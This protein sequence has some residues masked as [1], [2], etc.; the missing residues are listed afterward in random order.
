MRETTPKQEAPATKTARPAASVP[1]PART[2]VV[3]WS[4]AGRLLG[5]QRTRGN[6]YVSRLLGRAALQ[7]KCACGSQ[8]GGGACAACS[9]GE[10]ALRRRAA[11]GGD[12]ARAT[13]G[14]P[15]VV[16]E[17]LAS[18][19]RPLEDGAREYMEERF[20][21][22]FGHVRV[23]TGTKA[24][25]S[26]RAVSALAYTVGRDIVFGAGGYDTATS[27]G[28]QLLA[29]ELTHTLQQGGGVQRHAGPFSIS[30][31]HD[32]AEMEADEVAAHIESAAAAGRP[33]AAQEATLHRQLVTPLAPGGGF[34]G[35]LDRDRRRTLNPPAPVPWS[36]PPGIKTVKVWLK[37]FIPKDVPGVTEAAPS[38]HAGLT[39]VPGPIP[40]VSDCFLT[41][42]RGF[43]A[44][45]GASS[46]MHSE[47]EIDVTKPSVI[48]QWNTCWPSHEIDCGD[49]DVECNARAQ[50]YGGYYGLE[51]SSPSTLQISLAARANNACYSGSPDI[52]YD[53]T[54]TVSPAARAVYFNGHIDQFP[55]YEM[56]ATADGGAGVKLF[57]TPPPPGNTPG[58]LVHGGRGANRPQSGNATI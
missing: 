2:R 8:A 29:H 19:G 53:G 30:D 23:H 49:G 35:L 56:Y 12:G 54:V 7:R 52:V 1:S 22:D 58:D 26:A 40:G 20:G 3:G 57:Q 24:E 37:A 33:S 31:P 48:R 38:P 36:P 50:V 15:P 51:V 14:V 4:A 43:S 13:A 18:P 17:V 42:Q 27:A 11:R 16:H 28:R 32:A 39:M 34:S 44:D 41:D 21:V 6:R 5:L 25:E 10:T 55:A 47:V 46:R 9:E 45:I